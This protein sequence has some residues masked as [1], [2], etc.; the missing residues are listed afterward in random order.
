MF[1]NDNKVEKSIESLTDFIDVLINCIDEEQSFSAYIAL[2][3]EKGPDWVPNNV[4]KDLWNTFIDL[5]P[6][7]ENVV[8]EFNDMSGTIV[9]LNNLN[10]N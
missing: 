10:F 9:K 6:T 8:E 3:K 7:Y 1:I 4:N 5:I 2:Y